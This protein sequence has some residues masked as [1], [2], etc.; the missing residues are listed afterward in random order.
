MKFKHTVTLLF[1]FSFF[2]YNL[3]PVLVQGHC[4]FSSGA[5]SAFEISL[6]STS[7]CDRGDCGKGA[8]N[9]S[10]RNNHQAGNCCAVGLQ[11][12]RPSESHPVSQ[13]LQIAFPL[14]V[15]LPSFSAVPPAH[16]ADFRPEHPAKKRYAYFP[17]HQ[18]P[19]RAPPLFLS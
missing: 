18:I 14:I 13:T 9:P 7:I 3:C 19:A 15:A 1:L 17:V 2:I 5:P 12:A 11:L 16:E 8:E 6:P 4:V 10:Q